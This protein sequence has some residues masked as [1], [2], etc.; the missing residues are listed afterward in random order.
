MSVKLVS[1]TLAII[2]LA[3]AVILISY[4]LPIFLISYFSFG[5]SIWLLGALFTK[6]TDNIKIKLYIIPGW[7]P[8]LIYNLYKEIP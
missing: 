4:S 1:L 6:S 8:R 3:G 2:S 5:L 7:F